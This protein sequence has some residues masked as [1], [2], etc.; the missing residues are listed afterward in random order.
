MQ[1]AGWP[2]CSSCFFSVTG[3]KTRQAGA[4][5]L[6]AETQGAQGGH[7]GAKLQKALGLDGLPVLVQAQA[8]FPLYN[9]DLLALK[10]TAALVCEKFGFPVGL[11]S[12]A[13]QPTGKSLS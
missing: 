4:L 10:V 3:E 6:G 5:S 8:A 11:D 12:W 2:A 9:S 7:Q 13:Y 1:G